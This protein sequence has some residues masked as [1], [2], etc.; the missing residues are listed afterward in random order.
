MQTLKRIR[1]VAIVLLAVACGGGDG[2]TTTPPVAASVVITASGSGPL[3][4]ITETRTASVVVKD[5]SQAT[6]ANAAVTWTTSNA[7]VATVSGSGSTATITA[8]GNGS[9]VITAASGSKQATLS[10][11]VAQKFATLAVTPASPSLDIGA[12]VTLVAS[13]RDARNTAISGVTG[14]TFVT[15]DRTKALVDAATGAVTAIAPGSATMTASLTR[16]G[17]TATANGVVTVNAPA[18]L[19]TT[20]TVAA[21]TAN[22]FAPTSVT[23]GVGGTVNWSFASN[24]NVLF[25]T[26]G[27]PTN[28]PTTG[29]GTVGRVFGTLGTYNYTCTLHAGMN[30]IVQVAAPSIFAQMNGANERPNANTSTANGAAVFTRNGGTVAYTVA[31]QGIAS[32]PTGLHIH[33]PGSAAVTAGIIVDL[34]TTPLTTAS[35]VLTGT[36]TA[37]NI[38]PIGGQPAISMDSLFV[39][40]Q[41]G[42]AYVNVHSSVFPGGEIRGQTGNP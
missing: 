5:A 14:A 39:L 7:S 3:V 23:V 36:F 33:A 8:T 25:S 38:R 30:G 17:I 26:A 18:A 41:T 34:L 22:T 21:S 31:F 12:S 2:G 15:S 11:D 24:H 13:A 28:I 29:S 6:I 37:T 32:A 4:S 16:D 42:N 35:G 19:A 20:V 40:L 27:A 1:F 9:A 10:V